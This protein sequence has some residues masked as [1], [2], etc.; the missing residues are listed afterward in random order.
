MRRTKEAA[1]ETK[2]KIIDAA[3]E[4][5]ETNGYN[6]TRIE[7]IAEKTGMTRGAVYWHFKNKDDLY[8]SIFELFEKRL[9]RLLDESKEKTNSQIER[10]RWIIVNM[11]TRPDILVGFRQ[12][13]MISVSNLRLA[14][15]SN[16][17]QKKGESVAAKYIGTLARI[18]EACIA[19]GEMR[20][21][22]NSEHAAW[23]TAFCIAGAVGI[24]LKKPTLIPLKGSADD[25]V[26]LFLKGFVK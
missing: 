20:N 25:I 14:Q 15:T 2:Q 12:M 21:D 10:L 19:A 22:I 1:E 4:L 24:N 7:D 6:A 8:M 3:V 5:F 16:V 17:L 26:N 13:K 9:D 18:I 23:L 11:I